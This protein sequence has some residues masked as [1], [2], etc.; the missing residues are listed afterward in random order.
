VYSFSHSFIPWARQLMPRMHLSFWLIVQKLPCICFIP[1]ISSLDFHSLH[2]IFHVSC[3]VPVGNVVDVV[4]GGTD[5]ELQLRREVGQVAHTRNN[6]L[7]KFT[8]VYCA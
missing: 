5:L 4:P 1:V 3:A 7:V 8:E 2:V 6:P